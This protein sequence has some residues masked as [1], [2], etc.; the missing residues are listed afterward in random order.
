MVAITRKLEKVVDK[1]ES[2]VIDF[3]VDRVIKNEGSISE[4]GEKIKELIRPNIH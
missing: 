4:L 3:N 1:H 2:E